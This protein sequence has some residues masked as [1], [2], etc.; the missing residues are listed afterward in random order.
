MTK[1]S[2]IGEIDPLLR[3]CAR[4]ED[5]DEFYNGC[6][7]HKELLKAGWR[8]SPERAAFAADTI[9]EANVQVPMR[10]GVKLRVDI[11]RP[12]DSDTV[13]V[14]ALIAWSPYG[15]SGQG[16]QASM[17][18]SRSILVLTDGGG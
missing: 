17:A 6:E 7:E 13:K 18:Y 14:P 10:D 15:K 11:F 9:W 2:R 1:P 8:K 12:A 16:G 5:L 4:P 3:D